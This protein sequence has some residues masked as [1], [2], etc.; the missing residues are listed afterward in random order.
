MYVQF[1]CGF[2]APEG[3]LNFDASPTLRF[4]RIPLVGRLYTRNRQRFPANVKYGDI[5][6]GL[7]I[8]RRSCDGMYASHV[9]E[10]L[11]RD[12]CMRALENTRSYLKSGGIFR[13]VVPDLEQL[14]RDYA[15]QPDGD[16]FMRDSGLGA[17]SR[18]LLRDAIGNSAHR[19]LWDERSMVRALQEVGFTKIRRAQ[20][21][22]SSD[23]RFAD[24]EN[25]ERFAGCLGMEC[26]AP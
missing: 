24:V 6:R 8:D 3:W 26:R 2:S 13:L 21:N 10:H 19:W 5:V 23:P 22:D 17:E 16:R 1:G 12:D 4:E 14:V 25:A 7:P 18:S 20:F 11:A 15:G 9:L